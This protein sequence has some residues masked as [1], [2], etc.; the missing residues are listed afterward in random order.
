[1]TLRT[2]PWIIG[3][4]LLAIAFV[5]IA[6]GLFL[7]R[8][9]NQ[10]YGMTFSRQYAEDL[11]V[12]WREAYTAILKDLSPEV[13]RIPI[14]WNA[15]EPADGTFAFDDLDWMMEQANEFDVNIVLA[16]GIKVPRWPEC[17]IPSWAQDLEEDALLQAVLAMEQRVILRYRDHASLMR[18]QVENE[19]LFWY[20]EC[21]LPSL[22]RLRHEVELV[23][24]LDVAHP[25]LLTSS[26]EQATWFELASLADVIGV[27]LYRF[28]WNPALG[29]VVF[30]HAP[31]YYR[32]HA[33]LVSLVS[34]DPVIITELQMEPWYEDGLGN[35]DGDH[36]PFTVND[37]SEH[38]AFVRQ[39]NISEVWLWGAEWWYRE[40]L[41]GRTEIW[42]A[43]REIFDENTYAAD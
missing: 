31:W 32:L 10:V 9:R 5:A 38:I 17:H 6:I 37:F 20:G 7:F 13:V 15:I 14:E 21:P 28:S 8:P 27:S 3:V 29:P 43:A 33:G 25:V 12:D 34:G 42:D 19:P 36:I 26:G 16:L 30:P 35:D 1:M 23:H 18:W 41:A 11:G 2:F 4:M 24:D 40:Y 39:T 22:E